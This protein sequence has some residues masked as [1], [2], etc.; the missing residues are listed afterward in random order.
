MDL[1]SDSLTW[2][3]LGW[4]GIGPD[5]IWSE[6]PI[7]KF[8]ATQILVLEELLKVAYVQQ[9]CSTIENAET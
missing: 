9:R 5:S 6:L 3:K 8:V 2:I 1:T 7:S 4:L